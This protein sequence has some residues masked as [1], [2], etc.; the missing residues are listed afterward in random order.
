MSDGVSEVARTF[1]HRLR[2]VL[3]EEPL[4]GKAVAE[5][6]GVH[7]RTLSRWLKSEGL[8]FKRVSNEARSD[9]AMQLLANTN[10]SLSEISTALKFSEP[11]AFTH[12]FRRW[13]GTTPSAWRKTLRNVEPPC[14]AERSDDA[15]L[16]WRNRAGLKNAQTRSGIT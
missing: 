4:N 12:A 2:A 16:P 5:T 6:L 13:T 14:C 11:A 9:V 1:S 8:N 15:R 3:N 10:M 7:R